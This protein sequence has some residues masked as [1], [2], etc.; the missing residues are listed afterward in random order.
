MIMEVIA[1][2]PKIVVLDAA[3]PGP[4]RI[5]ARSQLCSSVPRSPL[6]LPGRPAT[7]TPT[8]VARQK[9]PLSST[10]STSHFCLK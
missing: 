4:S 3:T 7:R 2:G 1:V 8:S 9:P 10:T 6:P 5:R